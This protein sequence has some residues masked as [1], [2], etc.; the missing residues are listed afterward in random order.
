MSLLNNPSSDNLTAEEQDSWYVR[1]TDLKQYTY[2]PRVTYY[3]YCFPKL[4]PMTYKMQAG[5]EAQER[6]TDL[7]ERRSLRAY[8]LSDGERHFHVPVRS[9]V[10]GCVGQIDMVIE[11]QEGG[12]HRLIPV[13]YKLSQRS[14][15]RHFQLQVACYGMMLEEMYGVSVPEAYIY[16]IQ[17]RQ[18]ERIALTKRLRRE[19]A[20]SMEA[21]RAM[22]AKQ[23][24]P[25]PT[26]HRA[27]CMACEYRRFC[28]DVI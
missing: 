3:M 18:A 14:P 2:C 15:G 12:A 28:N 26:P 19:V 5:I 7:E 11:T 27:Q 21:I 9:K 4:R 25:P 6:V 24:V 22:I 13:D 1:V 16:L 17:S 8:G 23:R 20:Q 10:M